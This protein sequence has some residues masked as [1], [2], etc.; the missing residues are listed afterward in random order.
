M[1]V[2]SGPRKIMKSKSWKRQPVHD[3]HVANCEM[4]TRAD[5]SCGGRNFRP[6]EE[7]TTFC[8]V[9]GFHN[10]ME[11]LQE[12]P[13]QT[14]ATAYTSEKTGETLICVYPQ[15]LNF[16]ETME[17]SL[18]NPNQMRVTGLQVSDDPFDTNRP[19]GIVGDDFY[20][21]FKTKGTAIYFE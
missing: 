13:I 8:Q 18:I 21:P 17:N 15:M 11:P 9:S 3:A 6:L 10:T 2:I 20:I 12:I 14:M 16:N 7:P 5:T 4:D 1:P 19:F